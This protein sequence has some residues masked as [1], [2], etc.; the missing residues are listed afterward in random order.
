MQHAGR[1]ASRE[2]A[3]PARFFVAKL[4]GVLIYLWKVSIF[5]AVQGSGLLHIF[6]KDVN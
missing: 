1:A 3:F 6:R 2:K 4:R 5:G